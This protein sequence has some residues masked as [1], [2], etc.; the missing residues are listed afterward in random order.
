MSARS[1]IIGFLLFLGGF[2]LTH[3]GMAQKPTYEELFRPQIH[4]SAPLNWINDPNGLVWHNGEYH[5]FYQFNP[6]G[7]TWGHM[8]WGHAVSRDLVHWRHLDVA[9]PEIGSV[10]A[11]SG[12]AVSDTRNTSGF[13]TA[14]NPPL[15]AI[16]TG[17]HTDQPLQDQRIAYSLDNG[18]TWTQYEGNPVI[19]MGKADFRDP[20]VIWYEPDQKWVMVTALSTEYRLRFFES[21]NLKEWTVLSDFGPAGATGGIWECPDLFPLTVDGQQKWV[22]IV[23]INPGAPS[24][25]SGAQYFVG[26]FDGTRF[27]PEDPVGSGESLWIDY[28]KDFYAVQ[29]F[30]DVPSTDGWRIWLAWMSNWQYAGVTPTAPWRNSMTVP[31]TVMLRRYPEGMRIVQH[32]VEELQLLRGNHFEIDSTPLLPATVSPDMDE[33][34]GIRLEIDAEFDV[35][36][37]S[38]VG[39]KVRKGAWEETV[40]GFDALRNRIFVDRTRSGR[41]DFSTDFPGIHSGP[42]APEEGRIRIHLLVDD[43]SIEVFGNDGRI[44]LTETIYASPESDRIEIYS[45]GG[46]AELIR[47][48]AWTLDSSWR[49]SNGAD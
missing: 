49:I 18:R 1:G 24:G 47:L 3:R 23:N 8:S 36:D 12:S 29:S 31:R 25:G 30:S 5:L 48:D 37:A 40:I 35:G 32:P 11:F 21:K 16:F 2:M 33:I 42:L 7:D 6:F 39:I 17:H 41:T 27:I 45:R 34:R 4:F 43:S 13:G 22:L 44:V 9:I 26:H 38:E 14:A 19:D 20:K 10:M 46:V 15:V 28:G